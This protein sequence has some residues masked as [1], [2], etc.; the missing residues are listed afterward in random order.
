[1]IEDYFFTKKT[2]WAL[3]GVCTAILL[4]LI[5]EAGMAA[6][7]H[8]PMRHSPG[9]GPGTPGPGGILGS[10]MPEQ[11]YIENGHG[12]VGTIA[13]VTL[14]TFILQSRGGLE[15][16]I[17]V[18]TSTV[19]TGGSSNTGTALQSGEIVIVVGD[20]DDTDNGHLEAR[21]IHILPSH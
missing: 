16:V 10:F 2:K 19:I 17:H 14:P 5:F 20:P 9:K 1:M 13:T 7:Q 15:Q 3:W 18:G 8:R 21:I 12:A 6:G 4:F 11:G